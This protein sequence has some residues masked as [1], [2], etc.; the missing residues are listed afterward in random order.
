MLHL[1]FCGSFSWSNQREKE[2][3]GGVTSWYNYFNTDDETTGSDE[4]LRLLKGGA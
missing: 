3:S 1:E 4:Q 2:S